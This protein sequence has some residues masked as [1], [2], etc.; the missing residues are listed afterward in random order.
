MKKQ[1][2][3]TDLATWERIKAALKAGKIVPTLTAAADYV[4]IPRTTLKDLLA[5]LGIRAHDLLD[6]ADGKYVDQTSG[7][8][9]DEERGGEFIHVICS[10][11]R[12]LT[13]EDVIKE[14]KVDMN[15]WAVERFKIG[16]SEGYRKDRTVEWHEVDGKVVQGDVSD[17]GKMLVVPMYH[18]EVR[19]VR[20]VDEIRAR[21]VIEDMKEDA[22]NYAPV[23]APIKYKKVHGDAMFEIAMPDIHFG[24]L[25]WAEETGQ[26]YDIQIAEKMVD[27]VLSDLLA[28]ATLYPVHKILLPIGND[29]YNV[30][31]KDN[32]TVNGTPQQEDTRWQKTYRRGRELAV[33]MIEMC[34]QIAPVDVLIIKGNHDEEKSFYMGDGLCCWFHNNPNVHIDNGAMSRKYYL[35]GH[36]LIGFTHG[37]EEKL[38][39]LPSLMPTEVPDLWAKS[40][41]REFHLGH[42]HKKYEV[43]EENGVVVRLLRSLVPIDAWTFDKGFVGALRAAEGFVWDK[44]KGLIAQFTATP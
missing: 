44:N 1:S 21:S 6:F 12:M 28:S 24:R 33:H 43:N 19:F 36:S 32:T 34:S 37:D 23:Y 9:W 20:K 15:V 31:S 29:F 8:T 7:E 42:K 27:K 14:C 18:I 10:S 40:T 26:D 38:D 3:A 25:T 41:Y 17:S 30:N 13:Q 4:G 2:N 16:T 5:R 39:K 35:Y 22:L 11:P